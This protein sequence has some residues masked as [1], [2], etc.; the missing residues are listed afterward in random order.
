M[1]IIKNI[2][3]GGLCISL[4]IGPILSSYK[5]EASN[6]TSN[7]SLIQDANAS[8]FKTIGKLDL[9]AGSSNN[10]KT[11][12][13]MSKGS[14]IKYLGTTPNNWFKVEH[15]G[16][17]GYVHRNNVTSFANYDKKYASNS[18]S[19]GKEYRVIK[20][21]HF[22]SGNG[23]SFKSMSVIPKG[24][25][26]KYLETTSNNW[27]K[28]EHNNKVGYIHRTNVTT[29]ANYDRTYSTISTGKSNGVKYKTIKAL[30]FRSGNANKYQSM[31]VI[32]QGSVVKHLGT[33]SNDWF[34]VECEGRIGYIHRTNVTSFANYD[35]NYGNATVAP[36]GNQYKTIE[37]L[38]L[39]SN[40]SDSSSTIATLAKGSIV[41]HLG[42]VSGGWFKL[43]YNGK[44]GYIHRTKVTSFA[45]YE[46]N[47]AEST[48]GK[49][50]N[51]KDLE[52]EV[53]KSV[54]NRSNNVI[55]S[56]SGSDIKTSERV[57]DIIFEL[58]Q[59]GN[60]N[61][62]N[63][64]E[65]T[66]NLK[67]KDSLEISIDFSYRTT[68]AQE[69]ELNNMAKNIIH[70]I[71]KTNM[72]EFDKVKAVHDYIV[73]TTSYDLNTSGNA[74]T[75]YT[76][77]KEGKGSI[78]AYYLATSRLLN[79]IGIENIYVKGQAKARKSSNWEQHAW[80][81]AKVNGKWYNLDTAWD[82]PLSENGFHN[83]YYYF[84]V[85][86]ARLYKDHKAVSSNRIPSAT[87]TQ[88]DGKYDGLYLQ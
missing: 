49:V 45:N 64:A 52:N 35:K 67:D 3:L 82:F 62:G 73:D 23:N 6:S 32:P 42:T 30:H 46:S 27:F 79:E 20:A 57:S 33:T 8:E 38:D 7:L 86:D 13:T 22:R 34:K 61:L 81:K 58:T 77:L 48:D 71:S 36:S 4:M 40:N 88:Y 25:M 14:V 43:E 41:K 17:T 72:S 74:H 70:Q 29:F 76:L 28:V 37:K 31:L 44:V 83:A 68:D 1:K 84:M 51:V 53:I 87:D 85:S 69:A 10:E 47:Y 56:Y 54:K 78:N 39:K 59:V 55:I 26:V 18:S 5:V 65:W 12:L 15:K 60:Y 19:S 63:I 16:E 50:R 24:D 2:L 80:N 75:A 9:K 66:V 11:I 21:L